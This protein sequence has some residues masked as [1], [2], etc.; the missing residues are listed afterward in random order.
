MSPEPGYNPPPIDTPVEPVINA[1]FEEARRGNLVV[2]AGAGLSRAWPAELPGGAELGRRLDARLQALVSGYASPAD[3]EDLVGVADAGAAIQ[4][5]ESTLRGEVL[6]LASFHEAD[7]NYGHQALAE[8]LLEGGIDLLLLWNWDDCIERVDVSPERLQVARC[9]PDLDDLDQPSIAKVHGCATR[10][11]TLLITTSDL[12]KPP[13]WTDSAFRERLRGKTT[14][15]VGVGDI[16]DYAQRRLEQLRDELAKD[17][18]R[19]DDTLAIYVVSP[20]IRSQWDGSQWATLFPDLPDERKIELSADDFMDRLARRWA[21]EGLDELESSVHLALSTEVST[22]LRTLRAKLGSTGAAGAIRWCRR[23][24][25]GQHVGG[26]VM[27]SQGVKQLLVALA[28]LAKDEGADAI[29]I[30]GPS[31]VEVGG[32]RMEAL[33]AC[34]PV[35]ADRVRHR[36]RQ[37]AEELA[38]QGSIGETA[39]FLVSG[40]VWGSLDDEPDTELDLAIGETDPLDL[41]A[42]SSAVKLSFREASDLARAL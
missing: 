28:V 18:G 32:H 11:S 14:V 19:E 20:S 2:C 26:S 12:A 8:L 34:Q 33:V 7:P 5:G 29:T 1:I 30:R 17:A 41:V 23:A 10:R 4:G 36:A 3:P 21:R 37:R 13:Y 24:A 6:R 38:D 25:V 35:P 16:A 27:L 39:T 15:F 22:S 9:T 31:A 40:V 42:G